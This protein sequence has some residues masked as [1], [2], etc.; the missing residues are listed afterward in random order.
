LSGLPGRHAP[1]VNVDCSHTEYV[2]DAQDVLAI[3][4]QR[5]PQ[6]LPASFD[7]LLG[8]VVARPAYCAGIGAGG[9]PMTATQPAEGA[10]SPTGRCRWRYQAGHVLLCVPRQR[11]LRRGMGHSGAGVM[12]MTGAQAR[13]APQ[14]TVSPPASTGGQPRQVVPLG[15][16]RRLTDLAKLWLFPCRQ[17]RAQYSTGIRVVIRAASEQFEAGR[18]SI[19]P[20]DHDLG[21]PGGCPAAPRHAADGQQ[22]R[23]A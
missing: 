3:L 13:S 20:G 2:P 22:V 18:A 8:G 9:L 10:I 5:R 14:L 23:N 11:G 12:E 15:A 19:Q 4:G 7:L 17:G 21:Q 16:G 6:R 1:G